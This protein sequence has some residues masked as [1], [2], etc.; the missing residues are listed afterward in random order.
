MNGFDISPFAGLLVL[1]FLISGRILFLKRNGISV[2]S[3]TRNAS[4]STAI[5]YA[6]FFLILLLFLFETIKSAFQIPFSLLP[7]TFTNPLVDS[8]IMKIVG[9]L[10]IVFALVFLWLALLHFKNSLRF[11]LDEKN[12]GELITTGIFSLSRNPFFLSID[13]YFLGI[14][15]VLPNLFFIGYTVLALV[16]IHFFILKEEKFMVEI[17]GRKYREYLRNVGRYF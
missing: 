12:N 9:I 7:E 3:G 15:L 10:F 13:L 6:I 14:S 4:K 2:S 5:L 17:Y 11:G 16:S 1:I 8:L